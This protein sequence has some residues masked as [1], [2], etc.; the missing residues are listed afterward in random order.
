M[1]VTAI[2]GVGCVGCIIVHMICSTA[3]QRRAYNLRYAAI[4]VGVVVSCLIGLCLMET[5]VAASL[6]DANASRFGDAEEGVVPPTHGPGVAGSLSKGLIPAVAAGLMLLTAETYAGAL[7]LAAYACCVRGWS[8]ESSYG[9][10][11]RN[12]RNRLKEVQL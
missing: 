9:D 11:N 1:V 2:V 4:G 6:A 10:L 12:I 3:A 5:R 7:H 8:W